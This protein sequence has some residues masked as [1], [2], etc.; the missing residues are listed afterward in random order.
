MLKYSAVMAIFLIMPGCANLETHKN[1]IKKDMT[2][3]QFKKDWNACAFETHKSMASYQA[4]GIVAAH[5]GTQKANEMFEICM[6]SKD[7][8]KTDKETMLKALPS[9]SYK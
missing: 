5:V 6:Q 2:I 4:S 3:E 8:D 9:L 1:W 7:Y